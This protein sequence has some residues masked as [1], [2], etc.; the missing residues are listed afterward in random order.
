[1]FFEG[2][3]YTV[4]NFTIYTIKDKINNNNQNIIINI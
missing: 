4:L 2:S 3:A 1:M